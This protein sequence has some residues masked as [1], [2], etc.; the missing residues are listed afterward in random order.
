MI[1]DAMNKALVSAMTAALL[2][3]AVSI[4]SAQQAF[5]TPDEAASAPVSAAKGDP[6]A[7][8]TVLGRT[9]RTSYRPVTKSPTLPPGRNLSPPMTQSTGSLGRRQQGDH[10]GSD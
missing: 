8:V 6:K 2:C 1:E 10:G 7:V 4:A 3:T 9:V 5:K